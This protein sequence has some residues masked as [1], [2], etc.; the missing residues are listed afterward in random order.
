MDRWR[1]SCEPYLRPAVAPSLYSARMPDV[2]PLMNVF[3][4]DVS[5]SGT[6][7]DVGRIAQLTARRRVEALCL[8]GVVLCRARAVEFVEACGCVAA[9]HNHS[10][11]RVQRGP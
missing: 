11:D 2:V 4:T 3:H 7:P 5:S 10:S 9:R 8:G 6:L 1:A